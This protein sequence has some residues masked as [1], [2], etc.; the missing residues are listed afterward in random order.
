MEDTR[1]SRIPWNRSLLCNNYI[2]TDD[3]KFICVRCIGIR[4]KEYP[5]EYQWRRHYTSKHVRI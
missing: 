4:H 3:H 2:E 1:S 5:S